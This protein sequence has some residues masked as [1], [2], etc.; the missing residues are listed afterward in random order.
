MGLPVT[1]ATEHMINSIKAMQAEVFGNCV[2]AKNLWPPHLLDLTY[3]DC[4]IWVYLKQNV[5]KNTSRTL[6]N[7]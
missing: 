5:Y 3:P 6:K 2:I 4:S 7:S 1:D